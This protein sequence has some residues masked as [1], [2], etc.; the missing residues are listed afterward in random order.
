[1]MICGMEQICKCTCKGCRANQQLM[2]STADGG[3]PVGMDTRNSS[4][5][6]RCVGLGGR[7]IA[8]QERMRRAYEA[9]REI[10]RRHNDDER[11]TQ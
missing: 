8:K 3:L 7:P 1:M 10:D 11:R 6:Q 9:S 4:G 5:T 2:I